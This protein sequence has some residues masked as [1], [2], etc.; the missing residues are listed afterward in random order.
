VV[1]A[2]DGGRHHDDLC[3]RGIPVVLKE[4]DQPALDRGWKQFAATTASPSSA[5]DDA[6][7]GRRPA[8]MIRPTLDY[9]DLN[10]ATSSRGVFENME[11]KKQVFARSTRSPSPRRSCL[12]Y[13]DAQHDEIAASTSRRRWS[14]AITFSVRPT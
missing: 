9:N 4:V 2:H 11:L 8:G 14:S 6:I 10:E 3:Q 1:G 5:Q 7:A 12:Q 13:V